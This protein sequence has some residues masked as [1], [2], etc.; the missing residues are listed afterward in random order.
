MSS[1]VLN[2]GPVD[3]HGTQGHDPRV[4]EWQERL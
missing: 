4:K 1:A 2:L 3:G